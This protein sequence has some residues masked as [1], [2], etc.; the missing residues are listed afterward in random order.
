MY[1]YVLYQNKEELTEQGDGVS[2]QYNGI[3]I[4]LQISVFVETVTH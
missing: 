3:A 1:M 4:S 2:L